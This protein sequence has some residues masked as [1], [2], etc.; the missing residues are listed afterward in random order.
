MDYFLFIWSLVTFIEQRVKTKIDYK[1]LEVATGFSYRH[2]RGSYKKCT[3]QTLSR[4]ILSRKIANAAFEIQCTQKTI[5]EISSDYGFEC[6]DTFT[7]AF[8]REV[9]M[10]PSDFRKSGLKVGRCLLAIG[11]YGPCIEE[12]KFTENNQLKRQLKRNNSCILY[13]VPSIS[14]S[15][16]ERTPFIASLKACLN[17][18]G[19]VTDYAYLMAG[20][21]AAFRLRW[22]TNSWDAGNIDIMC[23]YH[24]KYEAFERA[25]VAAGRKYQILKREKSVK[26]DFIKFIKNEIDAGRP[27]LALGIIGPP[28]ACVIT[29]YD[30]HGE[31]LIGW[32]FF[33]NNVEFT[34]H[35][36]IDETGYFRC[37]KW[38]ENPST[39]AVMSIGEEAAPLE[40]ICSIMQNAL[41][42]MQKNKVIKL[43]HYTN[44]PLEYAGGI[45]AYDQWA[46]ALEDKQAFSNHVILPLLYERLV[47][48]ADAQVMLEEGRTCAA[49]FIE[50]ASK[51]TSNSMP[52]YQVAADAF[53]KIAYCASQ[54]N[55]IEGGEGWNETSAKKMADPNVR[56][57]LVKWIRRA[58]NYEQKAI[59]ALKVIVEN[60]G[61]K[62]GK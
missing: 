52:E 17:Y 50:W 23:T 49:E 25:F 19:Q 11:V 30:H 59:D 26:A 28:E 35:T 61:E 5:L 21:G 1:E 7:R 62:N 2:I 3:K 8:K 29:G 6:Y 40:N 13:G 18:M 41:D 16:D 39:L 44:A 10:T 15:K 60:E 57:V 31:T 56:K 42:V 58:K 12:Q 53:R 54:M 55:I 48:Q 20:S 36:S 38:W 14:A 32:N 22:N 4:Y 47:C 9:K 24:D 27:V 37:D 45:A 51:R 34:M 46:I 33:Q 43:Q